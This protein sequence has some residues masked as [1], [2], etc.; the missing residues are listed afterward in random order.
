M[1]HIEWLDRNADEYFRSFE[2]ARNELN[3]SRIV[4][5]GLNIF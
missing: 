2:K 1:G 3:A 5:I 4:G